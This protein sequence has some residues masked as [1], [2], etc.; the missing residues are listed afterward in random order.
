MIVP[1]LEAERA[2]SIACFV[3]CWRRSLE[4]IRAANETG[5]T[6]FRWEWRWRRPHGCDGAGSAAMGGGAL[7][8]ERVSGL[9]LSPYFAGWATERGDARGVRCVRA[10]EG[11]DAAAGDLAGCVDRC[12]WRGR[13]GG[14]KLCGCWARLRGMRAVANRLQGTGAAKRMQSGRRRCGSCWRLRDGGWTRESSVEFQMR[15]K[16]ESA[17]DELATLDFDGVRVEYAQALRQWRGLRGR[18]RLRRSRVMLR[19]R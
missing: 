3:R 11:A 14:R 19:C 1:G 17:L 18:R 5:L 10:A 15:R 2:R 4:D 12:W 6:S 16:W 7:P 13:S 9:L 8:L